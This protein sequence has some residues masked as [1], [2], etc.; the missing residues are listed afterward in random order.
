MRKRRPSY[1]SILKLLKKRHTDLRTV[2]LTTLDDSLD[3]VMLSTHGD[4]D[5]DENSNPMK[6]AAAADGEQTSRL[7]TRCGASWRT[8][9]PTSAAA[10]AAARR[11]CTGF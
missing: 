3:M 9:M 1:C 11:A 5:D 8:R 10:A 4:K 6:T 2:R 7:A